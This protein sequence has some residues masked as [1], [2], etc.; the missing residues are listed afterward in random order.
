MSFSVAVGGRER[1][2]S[3]EG[4]PRPAAPGAAWSPG[5]ASCFDRWL[6]EWNDEAGE[7]RT[8]PS[9]RTSLVYAALLTSLS[10]SN[11]C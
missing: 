4:A 9:S 8:P 5:K 10:V 11:A 2:G 7:A 3:T 6:I 1:R